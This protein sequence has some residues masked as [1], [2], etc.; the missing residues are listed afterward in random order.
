LEKVGQHAADTSE[1]A[2]VDVR[3]P[4][5]NLLGE[6]GLGLAQIMSHLSQERMAVAVQALALARRAFKITLDYATTRRAFG[7]P[8]GMHQYNRFALAD[9]KTEIDVADA[10]IS[11]VIEAHREGRLT[12]ATAAQAKLWATEM[13]TRVVDR[14]VQLHGGYG[15]MLEYPIARAWIDSRVQTIYAGTSEVMREV[16]GRSLGLREDPVTPS[17]MSSEG[18]E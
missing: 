7:K 12:D 16:I 6:V 14:G 10:Y 15:Y 5:E 9:M 18:K 1:L 13:C 2:F 11:H 8:I 4:A 3:V 17:Q